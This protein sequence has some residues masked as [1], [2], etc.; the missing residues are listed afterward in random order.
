MLDSPH[1]S[2]ETIDISTLDV[3]QRVELMEKLWC[4]LAGDLEGLGPP[5]W[6]EAV[7]ESRKAEWMN[8]ATEAEDWSKVREELGRELG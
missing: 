5:S 1:M 7:L 8:R 3:G 2:K 6:H 4:S